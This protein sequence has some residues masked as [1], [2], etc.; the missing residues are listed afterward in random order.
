MKNKIKLY[1]GL[2]V[3]SLFWNACSIQKCVY[4]KG[5]NL[6]FKGFNGVK[7][8]T[9]SASTKSELGH[10]VEAAESVVS[11]DMVELFSLP[12]A[13]HMPV[14]HL[15]KAAPVT[16]KATVEIKPLSHFGADQSRHRI[17]I[18]EKKMPANV[19]SSSGAA[20]LAPD[21]LIVLL[22]IFIPPIAVALMTKGNIEKI[23]IALLLWILGVLPGVV[24]A[25]L[26]F[27]HY[28]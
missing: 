9:H 10:A 24:Y 26:V 28:L 12:E 5:F 14:V 4:S 25:F 1:L 3:I 18:P 11:D 8:A 6:D 23:L 22:C 21:W 27:L 16:E 17:R 19:L 13:K 2:I 20:P 7:K 15:D